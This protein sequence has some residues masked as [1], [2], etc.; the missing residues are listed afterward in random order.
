M[1]NQVFNPA[2]GSVVATLTFDKCSPHED[3]RATAHVIRLTSTSGC[4]VNRPEPVIT[5]AENQRRSMK[6]AR[7]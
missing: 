5:L 6:E 7:H 2:L 4:A 3:A 1:P